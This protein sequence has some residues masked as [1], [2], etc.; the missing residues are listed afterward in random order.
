MKKENKA[1]PFLNEYNKP[2]PEN[3]FM[4]HTIN[5][6]Y[7]S[8]NKY[9]K[10]DTSTPYIML[11][12]V[13]GFEK[14]IYYM[15][16]NINCLDNI[17]EKHIEEYRNFCYN[18]L[19]NHKNTVNNKLTSLRHYFEYLYNHKLISY[20]IALGV[21]R[22]KTEPCKLPTIFTTSQLKILFDSFRNQTN[23]LIPLIISRIVLTTRAK[24]QDILNMTMNDINME[25]KLLTID[26]V[27]YPIGNELY[28]CLKDYLMQRSS[29]NTKGLN[30]IFLSGRGNIYS[31]RTYQQQFKLAIRD[32][33]IPVNLSPRFL[34]T[35]FL[36]NMA[37]IVEEENLRYIS[38]QNKVDQYYKL[39]QNPLQ[40]LT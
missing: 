11:R 31:I 18:G 20:N 24:I 12:Q 37:K 17:T 3:T 13:E 21:K 35:T 10:E 32:T 29:L 30:H 6:F 25:A 34:R 8:V 16:P 9:S 2:L 7:F 5:C 39:L 23:G 26:S 27:E 38:R 14:F 4:T 1:Y 22:L 15:Y 40:N 33:N 19:C 28:I 36:F